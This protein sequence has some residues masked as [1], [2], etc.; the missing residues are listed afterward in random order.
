MRPID[1]ERVAESSR[2]LEAWQKSAA[3]KQRKS[4][5][6]SE[7]AYT[8]PCTAKK[9]RE[10]MHVTHLLPSNSAELCKLWETP[11]SLLKSSTRNPQ[12]PHPARLPPSNPSKSSSA[13]KS[14]NSSSKP[15]CSRPSASKSSTPGNTP[16]SIS[17]PENRSR[18]RPRPT[19][20]TWPNPSSATPSPSPN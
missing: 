18:P 15:I 16:A 1:P 20:R 2:G 14:S 6:P 3:V 8:S 5:H 4:G 10:G 11:Q 9:V 12:L 17:T 13:P 19:S 7:P